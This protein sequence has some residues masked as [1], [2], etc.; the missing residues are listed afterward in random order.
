MATWSASKPGSMV[1]SAEGSTRI[2]ARARDR[3]GNV[4]SPLPSAVIMIDSS[5]PVLTIASPEAREYLHVESVLASFSAADSVSGLQ[6]VS[7]ALD[8]AAV[9]NSQ[10]MSLLTQTLGA[11]TIEVF[12]S[13]LAGNS[14]RQSVSFRIV[15]TIDSLIAAV[16]IYAQQGKIGASQQ[17]GLLAKLNDAKTALARGNTSSASAKLRDF[18]DQCAAQSG[19]VISADAAVVLTADAQHVLGTL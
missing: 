6:S 12:A 19:R 8:G 5:A 4:E 15:A 17:K 11:H 1:V 3:A 9:Q 10:S 7:A 14:A 13:D 18:I 2:T 16:N